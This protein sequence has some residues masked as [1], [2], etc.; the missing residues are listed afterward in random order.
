MIQILNRRHQRPI[1]EL[2][3]D[4]RDVHAP[5]L[6]AIRSSSGSRS[7]SGRSGKLLESTTIIQLA[8]HHKVLDCYFTD[9]V[10]F[11]L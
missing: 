11:K 1:P 6:V 7:R 8:E 5:Q 9:N 3:F 4:H 2:P 10:L